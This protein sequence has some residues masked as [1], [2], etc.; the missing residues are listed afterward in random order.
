MDKSIEERALKAG[1]TLS[2]PVRKT[3]RASSI[4]FEHTWESECVAA[5]RPW[6]A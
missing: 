3:N 5:D 6:V 4:G 1:K 2:L